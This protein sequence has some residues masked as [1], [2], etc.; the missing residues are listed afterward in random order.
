MKTIHL[1]GHCQVTNEGGW[2]ESDEWSRD[3]MS[4]DWT[5]AGAGLVVPRGYEKF[6]SCETDIESGKC[7]A[8][9]AVYSTGDSFGYDTNAALEFIWVFNDFDLVVKAKE[10]LKTVKG[11]DAKI[12]VGDGKTYPLY[13]PWNGYF[14]SLSYLDI[15]EFVL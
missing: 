5:V 11:H 14:E 9:Y 10:Y 13:V 1:Y 4:Y 15:V 12:D 8:L 2:V 6:D 7:Y 3:S